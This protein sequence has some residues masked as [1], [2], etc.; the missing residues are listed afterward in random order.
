LLTLPTVT[1]KTERD[2]HTN[3]P[4]TCTGIYISDLSEAFG[5]DESFDVI[6]ANRLDKNKQYYDRD[7]VSGHRPMLK[8]DGKVPDDWL[9]TED[10]KHAR[11]VLRRSRII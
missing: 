6:G 3:T 8:F 5:A 7:Y 11:S 1:V 2:P 9:Q 10:R 4:A